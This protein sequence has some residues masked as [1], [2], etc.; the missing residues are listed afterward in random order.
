MLKQRCSRYGLGPSIALVAL[1]LTAAHAAC[2]PLGYDKTSLMALRD[3]GFE[4]PDGEADAFA[5][6]LTPCLAAPD[7]DLR[8]K[9]G[10]EAYAQLL[11]G[12]KLSDGAVIEL[13]RTLTPLM[14]AP[15]PAPGFEAPF[16]ALVLSEVA[17]ADRLG[18]ILPA[19]DRTA[20]VDQAVRYM[21]KIRDYRGF[22]ADQGWRHGVAHTAD[23]MLQLSVNEN[24]TAEHL[25]AMRTAIESQIN[26]Q[27]T[28]FYIYGEPER[29]ARPVLYMARAG[30]IDAEDWNAWFAALA[31]PAPMDAWGDA[32]SSQQ[33]LARKHNVK[34]FA[35]AVFAGASSTSDANIK[36]LKEPAAALLRA[37]P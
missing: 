2:P 10:Y 28:H 8:D 22:D 26:P 17:R 3:N 29:L 6:A 23:L 20:L 16:A 12:D 9:V 37:L 5:K 36:M 15:A 14:T 18:D 25:R 34:A 7:P 33:G 31:D 11:R 30:L 4:L 21:T 13:A 24:L 1:G 27:S 35:L 19:A 32:F